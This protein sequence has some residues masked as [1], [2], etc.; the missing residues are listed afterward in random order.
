MPRNAF[1]DEA[2][3]SHSGAVA[4]V[5]APPRAPTP[6]P[7]ARSLPPVNVNVFDFMVS[8]TAHNAEE[9][10]NKMIADDDEWQDEDAPMEEMYDNHDRLQREFEDKM[11]AAYHSQHQYEKDGFVYGED[12]IEPSYRHWESTVDLLAP[13]PA[14]DLKTPAPKALGEARQSKAQN[15]TSKKS[16]D[17][18]RKRAQVEDLDL[19]LARHGPEDEVMRDAD[20]LPT[21][22]MLHSGL[23]GVLSKMLSRGDNVPESPDYAKTPIS[24]M[25]RTKHALINRQDKLNGNGVA[26]EKERGRD[27]EPKS[28]KGQAPP[29]SKHEIVRVR[30]SR[31][32][33]ESPE[34]ERE[35]ERVGAPPGGWVRR[36]RSS[37]ET[38]EPHSKKPQ[39]KAI[40]YRPGS[41]SSE[42]VS[43]ADMFIS[44]IGKGPES[45]RGIS[46]HK[47]LKRWRAEVA[48]TT[49][50]ASEGEK[51]LWRAL[52]LRRNERGEIVLVA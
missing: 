29:P 40:E 24:P 8:E 1:V 51:D 34:R 19:T 17:K 12:P 25:K 9:D 21:P 3:D 44:L 16:T 26:R 50:V 5:D 15:G 18:K 20:G 38:R 52:R 45:D 32:K 27:P 46:L 22:A 41:V 31:K 43:M 10:E 48:G 13:P 2:L 37:S 36:R 47:C 6:P 33:R 49:S 42:E 28:K 23:T 35:R 11:Q 39:L 4:I 30:K 14:Y 7:A